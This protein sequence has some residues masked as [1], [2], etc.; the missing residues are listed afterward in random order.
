MVLQTYVL[1]FGPKVTLSETSVL[2]CVLVYQHHLNRFRFFAA[3]QNEP[4]PRFLKF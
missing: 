4:L 3:L 2:M 1:F